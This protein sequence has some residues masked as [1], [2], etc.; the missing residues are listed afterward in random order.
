MRC[1]VPPS[2]LRRFSSGLFPH[3]PHIRARGYLRL[4]LVGVSLFASL[5]ITKHKNRADTITLC[6]NTFYSLLDLILARK[7]HYKQIA[8]TLMRTRKHVWYAHWSICYHHQWSASRPGKCGKKTSWAIL[9]IPSYIFLIHKPLPPQQF[10]RFRCNDLSGL[11]KRGLSYA[12][13]DMAHII[14]FQLRGGFLRIW[15]DPRPCQLVPRLVPSGPW[16]NWRLRFQTS[17][18]VALNVSNLVPMSRT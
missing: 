12:V 11:T 9:S 1:G 8:I 13:F 10:R 3:T 2:W 15:I 17:R 14:N 4:L 6:L 5:S 7:Q 18:L 16:A